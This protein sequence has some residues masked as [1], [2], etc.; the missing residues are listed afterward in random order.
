MQRICEGSYFKLCQLGNNGWEVCSGLV[1]L[2]TVPSNYIKHCIT[3][4][5]MSAPAGDWHLPPLS[6]K[7]CDR[8]WPIFIDGII[9]LKSSIWAAGK[10]KVILMD[11][12]VI[13][14]SPAPVYPLLWLLGSC[15]SSF[16]LPHIKLLIW[17]QSF[18]CIE[19]IT[20]SC[21]ICLNGVCVSVFQK[22]EANTGICQFD[23][24]DFIPLKQWTK[25]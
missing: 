7:D 25:H 16:P 13:M 24:W 9:G 14:S 18:F 21:W 5:L 12:D 11:S 10:S 6:R 8:D 3:L 23:G 19:Q 15:S 4:T 22:S 20:K 17:S 1:F 2:C